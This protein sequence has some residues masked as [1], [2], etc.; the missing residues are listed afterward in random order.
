MILFPPAKVNLGLYITRKR[1]DGY[2]DIESVMYPLP[3]TD[4]LEILPSERF[5]FRSSGLVIEGSEEDNL[6]VKAFRLMQERHN[7][8]N[9]MIHLQKNIP[10]GAGLGGGSADAAYVLTGINMIFELGLDDTTLERYASELG[11]DCAFFVR[12]VPQLAKGR[13]EILTPINLSLQ[14][15]Y[16]KVLNPGIHVSTKLAYSN[17]VL[18]DRTYDWNDL[19]LEKLSE[20]K[21]DLRNDFEKTVFVEFPELVRIKRN[22]YDEGAVY[23]CMSGSGSTMIG[24][25]DTEPNV[26]GKYS[27]EKVLKLN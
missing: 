7:V 16:I 22:L 2:H 5:I 14:G 17:V 10:M 11:S 15:K 13:G 23:A 1:E 9:V 8:G 24:I 25:F 26:S 19:T 20:W 12:S 27:F 6:C 3:L 21:E 4:V 18:S